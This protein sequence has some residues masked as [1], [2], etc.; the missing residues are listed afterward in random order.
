MDDREAHIN[1]VKYSIHG[2]F[3]VKSDLRSHQGHGPLDRKVG[4]NRVVLL[5][6]L[7]LDYGRLSP[8]RA[9][10]KVSHMVNGQQQAY[11]GEG[12]GGHKQT[13]FLLVY[14]KL[15]KEKLVKHSRK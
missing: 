14:H 7:N 5:V 4:I 9:Y 15:E 13:T 11:S 1:V 6:T 10:S 2:E 8:D 3:G 12:E